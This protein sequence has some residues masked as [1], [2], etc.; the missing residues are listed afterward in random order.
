M[1]KKLSNIEIFFSKLFSQ[2]ILKNTIVAT[3]IY[4]IGLKL[5]DFKSKADIIVNEDI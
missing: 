4:I 2:V 1:D 5:K 3:I